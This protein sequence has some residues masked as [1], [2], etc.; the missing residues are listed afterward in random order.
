MTFVREYR[1][2]KPVHVRAYYRLR[3]GKRETVIS[4]FRSWP[5]R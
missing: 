2:E 4:H 3:Y 5:R 1:C